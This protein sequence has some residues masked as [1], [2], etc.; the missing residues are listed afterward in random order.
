MTLREEIYVSFDVCIPLH[1]PSMNAFGKFDRRSHDA[2]ERYITSIMQAMILGPVRSMQAPFCTLEGL[3]RT[4]THTTIDI[5]SKRTESSKM[6]NYLELNLTCL[7]GRMLYD[8]VET[9]RSFVLQP[10]PSSTSTPIKA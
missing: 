9:R 6:I 2:Y 7:H 3:T 10:V 4:S 5:G 8:F 1:I